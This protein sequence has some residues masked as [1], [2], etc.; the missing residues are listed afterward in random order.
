MQRRI[1]SFLFIFICLHYSVSAQRA[2]TVEDVWQNYVFYPSSVNGINWMNDGQFYTAQEGSR[3]VKYDITTGKAVE[4]LFG[5]TGQPALSF[6]DY[7]LNATEDKIVFKA[8]QES[9][10]RRS[11]KEYTYIYDIAN[12]ELQKIPGNKQSHATLSPD[13]QK[14]AFVRDNNLYVVNLSDLSE[15]AIT[16][17]GKFNFIINGMCDWVYEEE[18]AFTQAFEWSGDSQKIA[19][20]RFDESEVKEYNMQMWETGNLYPVDYRFKYPKAGEDN[21]KIEVKIYHL[22]TGKTVNVNIG[23][24]TDIYIPRINWTKNSDLLSLRRMNRLQNQLEILHVDAQTGSSEV[25]LKENEEKYIDITYTDDLTYLADGER[26]IHSSEKSGF[27]H[28]YLYDMQGNEL[29]A[30]TA[31]DWEA[32][33]ILGIDEKNEVIYFTSTEDSPMERQLYKVNFSGKKKEKLST[34]SGNYHANFSPDCQYYIADFSNAS[35][36]PV[37]T[38]NE[39]KNGSQLRVLEDN[40]ALMSRVSGFALSE[41]EFFTVQNSKGIDLNGWMLKPQGFD[42]SKQYPVLMF[43]YGGPGKQTVMNE[44]D[45]FNTFWFQSLASQGYIVVSVDNRGTDGRGKEFRQST[46]GHMGE[47]EYQDQRD[48]AL[49]LQSL[50]YVDSERVGIWGWS[51]G[52]YMSSLSLFLGGD[53]FKTA[54]AVA[55]V[56]NW[57]FYDTIYTERYLGLPQDNAKGYDAFSP[58]SHVAKMKEDANYLLVHGTGDD[59]VH[60]QNA[61]ALQNELIRTGKQFETFYYPNRNHGIY[62]GNTRL[63]LYQM[64]TDFILE[65]L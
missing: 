40:Q 31:G 24:E 17:D 4:T 14:V 7:Q 21:S 58:L 1:L 43:V 6:D 63:H 33:E 35:A 12:T 32:S 26:F 51:Y 34:E 28:L 16:T 18:F 38:L 19:F 48:A 49:Y 44:W 52:G 42:E 62:G 57:R 29:N 30:I 2:V 27:K 54:I 9:I 10:Y 41:K 61:V 59:N 64:M 13:G 25:I 36:A 50:P 15:T 3:V 56:A 65:N 45:S 20:I 39:G 60:F 5:K 47:F 46:Y 8:E 23:S 53:I 55:P 22:S 37:Y 11:T